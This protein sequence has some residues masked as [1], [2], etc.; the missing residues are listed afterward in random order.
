MKRLF[1]LLAALPAFTILHSFGADVPRGSLMELHS[2]ELF[3]GGCVVSSEAPQ[4]GRY[5]LRVWN[6]TGGDF[7]G[8]ALQGLQLAVLQT[9]PDNLA[10]KDSQPGDAVVYL[11]ETA[12]A[13]Q[14]A[15]LL[16]WLKASQ[17]DFHPAHLQTR[18]VP[19]KCLKADN[20][21]AFTAGDFISVN[22]AATSCDSTAC[23]EELWYQPR[24][25]TTAFT[26]AVNNTS[27]INEPL[28]NL[29]WT[30]DGKRSVFLARFGEAGTAGNVYVTMNELCGP[31]KSLF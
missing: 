11:P 12:T 19:M 24:T 28:L 3:A 16:A 27:R 10:M 13:A 14:R 15:T 29:T 30:D 4:G 7:Q 26:V 5:M 22:S 31:A 1:L 8:S 25:A 18:T 17:N 9:S 21:Y 6:F 23:G 2:C 20:H